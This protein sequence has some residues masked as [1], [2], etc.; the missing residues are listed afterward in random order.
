MKIRY[1]DYEGMGFREIVGGFGGIMRI[2]R[3]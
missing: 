1:E 2:I 3:Y